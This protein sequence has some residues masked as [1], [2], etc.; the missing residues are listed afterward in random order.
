MKK[1]RHNQRGQFVIEGV[2]L[3]IVMVGLFLSAT[4]ILREERFLAKLIGG[5]WER[6]SGMI[7]AGVW[8]P[9]ATARDRHPNQIARSNTERPD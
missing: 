5:P 6:V 9:P 7:E 2:L 1:S 4:R 8:D 3:M